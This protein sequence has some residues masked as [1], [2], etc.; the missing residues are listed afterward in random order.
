M[1]NINLADYAEML[2]K[3]GV[4]EPDI[5]KAK[6]VVALFVGF[7]ETNGGVYDAETAWQ[8]SRKLIEDG[9]NSF[10]TFV[11][12]ARYTSHAKHHGAFLAFLESLDGYEAQENLY[13]LIG[14]RFGE[15]FR[16]RVFRGIG[17]APFGLPTPEK[18]A[19][20]QPVVERLIEHL[21]ESAVAEMLSGCLRDLP[22]EMFEN[23]KARFIASASV[24]EYLIARKD[25][26][27]ARLEAC[28]NEGRLFFAQEITPEVLEYVKNDPEMGGGRRE[29]DVVY[30][31]KIPFLTKQFLEESDPTMKRYYYCHCPWM[32]EAIKSGGKVV[33]TFCNCS[34]GFHKKPW[35][36]ALGRPVKVDVIESAAD[37][38]ERCRFRIHL[39]QG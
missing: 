18:P 31:T 21:G 12:L 17:L 23:E 16:D 36:A 7:V 33:P 13:H 6:E 20:M 29:G 39:D 38:G 26:F 19:Y 10:D 28:M 25:A 11:F 27:V 9:Q 32:R 30:E 3:Q 8:F 22:D 37:G 24:D 2:A 15:T 1:E 34:A 5:A 4:S 35:E 14:E